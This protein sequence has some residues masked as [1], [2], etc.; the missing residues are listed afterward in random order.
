MRQIK[1]SKEYKSLY[2]HAGG[3]LRRS[4]KYYYSCLDLLFLKMITLIRIVLKKIYVPFFVPST[5]CTQ[6][7]VIFIL[8]SFKFTITILIKLHSYRENKTPKDGLLLAV[9]V[10]FCNQKL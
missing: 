4:L 6:K 2:N 8:F 7:A 1:P 9:L 3:V 5:G 10:L